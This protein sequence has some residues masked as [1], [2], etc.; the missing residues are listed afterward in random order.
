MSG[1]VADGGTKAASCYCAGDGREGADA[2]PVKGTAFGAWCDLFNKFLNFLLWRL[3]VTGVL[4]VIALRTFSVVGTFGGV[5]LGVVTFG[6]TVFCG[7][8]GGCLEA[9]LKNIAAS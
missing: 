8:E 9:T 7:V 6:C 4:A 5:T 1:E 2:C 3:V